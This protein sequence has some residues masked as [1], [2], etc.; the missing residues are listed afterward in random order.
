MV[1]L[2]E[3]VYVAGNAATGEVSEFIGPLLLGNPHLT[4]EK[5]EGLVTE[6]FADE[7]TAIEAMRTLLK[8]LKDE[9]PEDLGPWVEELAS[10]AFAED[11]TANAVLQAQLADLYVGGGLS[12]ERIRPDVL[13]EGP[14]K[15]SAAVALSR[16]SQGIWEMA[17]KRIQVHGLY[18]EVDRQEEVES[19][20][21]EEVLNRRTR[22]LVNGFCK[23]TPGRLRPKCRTCR[24]EG[25]RTVDDLTRCGYR[26]HKAR[27]CEIKR[28]PPDPS[29][30]RTRPRKIEPGEHQRTKV[31]RRVNRLKGNAVLGM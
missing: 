26:E 13:N 28:E 25:H 30:T 2:T 12:E 17:K 6:E 16:E 24:H 23:P 15:L 10:L 21:W 9:S 19:E 4:W 27:W 14:L 20:E 22:M 7:G 18:R 1:S 29:V 11:V 31:R 5:L 8:E 3:T